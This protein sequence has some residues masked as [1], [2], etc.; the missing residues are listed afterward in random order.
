MKKRTITGL[1][2]TLLLTAFSLA[3]QMNSRALVD[4]TQS[5][6]R[7]S[8]EFERRNGKEFKRYENAQ[9]HLSEFDREFTKGHFDKGKLDDAIDDV[10]NLVEHN[11]L[12]P[13]LRDAITSDLRDLRVMRAEHDH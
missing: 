12:D 6:L 10:K 5:D 1:L 4:R 8:L 7:R 11:T 2:S 9:H 3:A 13:E